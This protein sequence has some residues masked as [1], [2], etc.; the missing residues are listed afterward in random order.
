MKEVVVSELKVLV[1]AGVFPSR[2]NETSSIASVGFIIVAQLCHAFV[3]PVT[4]A[5]VA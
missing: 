3:E 1:T 5:Q 4:S 2:K